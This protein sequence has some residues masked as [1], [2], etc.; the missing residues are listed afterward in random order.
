MTKNTHMNH[1]EDKVLYGG[2]DGTRQAILALRDLKNK[3]KCNEGA[4]SV[5]WDGAPSIFAGTDPKDGKFFV[6]KK[7]IFNK[8]PKVYKT[9]DDID[10]EFSGQI[11]DK[12]KLCLTY[13]PQLGIEGVVQGDYLF[14]ESDVRT[15]TIKDDTY[16]VFH[17]NTIAYAVPNNSVLADSI[18]KARLGIV[19]HTK[20]T[21]GDNSNDFATLRAEYGCDIS[22]LNKT[23]DVFAISSNMT[24]PTNDMDID[25]VSKDLSECGKLFNQIPSETFTR[26]QT[27]KLPGLIEQFNNTYVREGKNIG[28]SRRHLSNFIAWISSKY[29][30]EIAS[31]KTE[32]GKSSQ[33]QKLNEL[34]SFFTDSTSD[35]VKK[36]FDLQKHLVSA[37][38]KVINT[39]DI[40]N[41]VKTFVKTVDGYEATKAEGYVAI[42]TLGG[43]A[44]KLVD[45]MEFSYNNFSPNILKGWEKPREENG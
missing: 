17:P 41:E 37:K 21:F 45:R 11:A 18:S 1:V 9:F 2:V 13:L 40:I 22:T 24:I 16:V 26:L 42:D 7:G 3:I 29:E 28:D 5:K 23:D 27:S 31:R 4:V 39:L 34:L 8:N 32:R 35:D 14:G 6:A 12:L 15:E 25:D 44:V 10:N 20:Y 36:I 38:I 43:D 33:R 30:A 19:L